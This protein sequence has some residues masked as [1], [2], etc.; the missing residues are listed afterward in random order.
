MKEEK[1]TPCAPSIRSG[2][3]AVQA[4]PGGGGIGPSIARVGVCARSSALVIL[5]RTRLWRTPDYG[6]TGWLGPGH[7]YAQIPKGLNHSA[8]G[9]PD[10]QRDYPGKPRF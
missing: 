3:Q 9:W 2:V 1:R 6:A 8:Q 10:S 4:S 7:C 5:C